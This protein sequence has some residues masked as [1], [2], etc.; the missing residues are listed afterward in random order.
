MEHSPATP[1]PLFTDGEVRV[2]LEE[3]A[4]CRFKQDRLER[5]MERQKPG[6]VVYYNLAVERDRWQREAWLVCT[7]LEFAGWCP[8]CKSRECPRR[9]DPREEI[10]F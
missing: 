7:M 8:V 1:A 10:P 3:L 6:T 5:H 2:M 4:R 9:N